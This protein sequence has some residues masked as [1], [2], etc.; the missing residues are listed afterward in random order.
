MRA[1]T[2]PESDI[3]SDTPQ[4]ANASRPTRAAPGTKLT[5]KQLPPEA[6]SV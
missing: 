5:E 2:S 3:K 4:S 1:E 6:A